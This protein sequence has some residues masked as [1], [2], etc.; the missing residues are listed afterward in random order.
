MERS[1][2]KEGKVVFISF[3]L[4]VLPQN[5]SLVD[6]PCA[7]IALNNGVGRIDMAR[8]IQKREDFAKRKSKKN[9]D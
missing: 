8:E 1:T 6:T 9:K 3:I 4:K 5:I 2:K 7:S